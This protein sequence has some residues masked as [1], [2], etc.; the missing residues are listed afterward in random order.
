MRETDF[1]KVSKKFEMFF[2]VG[3]V[4]HCDEIRFRFENN[5]IS[6][7]ELIENTAYINKDL[8]DKNIYE[9]ELSELVKK[10]WGTHSILVWHLYE[11][12]DVFAKE[13]IFIIKANL[14]KKFV[15]I[16]ANLNQKLRKFKN[17]AYADIKLDIQIIENLE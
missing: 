17:G 1:E 12:P 11:E 14:D 8:L 6:S 9:N 3:S 15:K 5:Q 13:K 4:S 16:L 10:M 7:I 2:K